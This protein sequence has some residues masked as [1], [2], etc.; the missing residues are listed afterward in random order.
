[1]ESGPA[2][3]AGMVF[4]L[5]GAG[6]LAWTGLRLRRGEPVAAGVNRVAS[7]AV[8]SVAATVA[9]ALAAYCLTR[10]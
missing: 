6:L 4:A 8:A 10:L 2:I 3:F 5:F 1:M 7:A 9:L